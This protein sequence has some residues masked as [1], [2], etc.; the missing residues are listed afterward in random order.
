M[1]WYYCKR[2]ANS[3]TPRSWQEESE[4]VTKTSS[5]FAWVVFAHISLMFLSIHSVHI[6]SNSK[7]CPLFRYSNW[8]IYSK[9][10]TSTLEQKHFPIRQLIIAASSLLEVVYSHAFNTDFMLSSYVIFVVNIVLFILYE[11]LCCHVVSLNVVL[12]NT[13]QF[14]AVILWFW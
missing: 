8:Y 3:S 10:R 11:I 13:I 12:D 1:P 7:R 14:F 9:N 6:V 4:S 2:N 5:V